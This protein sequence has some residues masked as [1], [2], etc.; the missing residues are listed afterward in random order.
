MKTKS[1]QRAYFD[2]LPN[3]QTC[4]ECG[5]RG[6]K[7]ELHPQVPATRAALAAFQPYTLCDGC[8]RRINQE[9]DHRRR[10]QL[11]AAPRCEVP[12]CTRRRAWNVAGV[13]LCGRHKTRAVAGQARAMP[14][15]GG[16]GLF[17]PVHFSREDVLRYATT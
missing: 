9:I 11:D 3:D 4:K 15:L 8:I 2:A 10:A 13:Q 1:W 14:A 12:G 17:L 7:S 6:T 5:K 16:I